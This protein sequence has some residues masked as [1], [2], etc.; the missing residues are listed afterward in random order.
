MRNGPPMGTF[1]A[2]PADHPRRVER[3]EATPLK[4]TGKDGAER[5]PESGLIRESA[6]HFADHPAGAQLCPSSPVGMSTNPKR[7]TGPDP[8][9]VH[10][11]FVAL[12]SRGLMVSWGVWTAHSPHRIRLVLG[13][14]AKPERPP[15]MLQNALRAAPQFG[16]LRLGDRR[17]AQMPRGN[18]MKGSGGREWGAEK[19]G[20][21]QSSWSTQL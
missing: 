13:R 17:R 7:P 9:R 14:I 12:N 11:S 21:T 2:V 1:R 15:Q 8:R 4:R 3:R 6:D 16:A 10:A 19:R 5:P 18:V 20:R